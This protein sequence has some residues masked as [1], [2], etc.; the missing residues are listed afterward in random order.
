M[1][2]GA[3][4]ASFLSLL[5]AG[6]SFKRTRGHAHFT[7]RDMDAKHPCFRKPHLWSGIP[8]RSLAPMTGRT[9]ARRSRRGMIVFRAIGKRL[10]LTALRVVKGWIRQASGLPQVPMSHL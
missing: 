2:F 1:H 4:F 8:R 7:F 6:T 5:A 3:W 9:T 10:L